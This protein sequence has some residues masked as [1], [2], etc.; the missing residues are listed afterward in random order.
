LKEIRRFQDQAAADKEEAARLKDLLLYSDKLPIQDL[1]VR[2]LGGE[3]VVTGQV[4]NLGRRSIGDI[5]LTAYFLDEDGQVLHKE[6]YVAKSHDG[7]P[8]YRGQRRR[9]KFSVIPAP[10]KAEDISLIITRVEF[11]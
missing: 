5:E 6:A 4:R 7:R 2:S 3:L 10:E 9:F 1:R 8:L 11:E